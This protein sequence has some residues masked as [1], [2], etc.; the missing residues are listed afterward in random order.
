MPTVQTP[1]KIPTTYATGRMRWCANAKHVHLQH[2]HISWES[3]NAT[4][5]GA[6]RATQVTSHPWAQPSWN[7]LHAKCGCQRE[8]WRPWRRFQR[9]ST[10]SNKSFVRSLPLF[11]VYVLYTIRIV[12]RWSTHPYQLFHQIVNPQIENGKNEVFPA[13]FVQVPTEPNSSKPVRQNKEED[14]LI[15]LV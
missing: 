4:H 15:V 14:M 9:F 12:F 13:R 8:L 7:K 5:M 3:T 1:P 2:T 11:S 6:T 10:N